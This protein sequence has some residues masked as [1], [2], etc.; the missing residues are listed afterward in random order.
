MFFRRSA[1]FDGEDIPRLRRPR[2]RR[3]L[4]YVPQ[5]QQSGQ[6]DHHGESAVVADGRRGGT[7]L[8]DEQLDLFP[9]TQGTAGPAGPVY[10]RAAS[11]KQLAIARV[12]I[13]SPKVPIL[14]EPTEGIQPSVVA[15]TRGHHHGVDPPGRLGDAAGR[16]AHRLRT[17]LGR[18]A[19]LHPG[20][21]PGNP[22]RRRRFRLGIRCSCTMAIDPIPVTVR[23]GPHSRG[24]SCTF[25]HPR[26]QTHLMTEAHLHASSPTPV[27][28]WSPTTAVSAWSSTGALSALSTLAF[29]L[30]VITLVV[31][32]F[33]YRDA[34]RHAIPTARHRVPGARTAAAVLTF[35][36]VRAI[37]ARW[38]RPPGECRPVA[39]L[40]R[41][42]A[43]FSYPNGPLSPGP[44]RSLSAGSDRFQ[45]TE[46]HRGQ[47]G[48]QLCD[49]TRQP[50]RRWDRADRRD[51]RHCNARRLG[52]GTRRCTIAPERA[53]GRRPP[54]ISR[55]R[56]AAVSG[57][58]R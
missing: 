25:A 8:I 41:R 33:D 39:V 18:A 49:Q 43:L 27:V 31:A 46:T 23:V 5:G 42:L 7:T 19:L 17:G 14:D 10:R 35:L 1:F 52:V 45:L 37:R 21:R 2:G 38:A 44:V 29:V 57:P 15:E 56:R 9:A 11:A 4:A 32:G 48:R 50:V 6:R 55:P 13:T 34:D 30:G 36:T 20:G 26:G 24:V 16:A 53:H 3:G 28:C 51:A 40:D 54:T 12:L 22:F 47:P 58:M